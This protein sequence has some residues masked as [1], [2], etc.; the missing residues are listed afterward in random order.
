MAGKL[1]PADL[2]IFV[3]P[4]VFGGY[5]Y[6]L[7]KALDRQIGTLLPFVKKEKNGETHHPSRYDKQP[8]F[9][10]VGV[11]ASPDADSEAISKPSRKETP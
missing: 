11:S 5:S 4:I 3:T 10:V 7:K 6:E 1:G 9:V 2:R 8:R